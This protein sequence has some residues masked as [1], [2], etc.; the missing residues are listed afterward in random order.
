MEPAA[1]CVAD[2]RSKRRWI[3]RGEHHGEHVALASYPRCGNTLLRSLLEALFG[4]YT[5]CD[6]NP[7]RS[8]SKELQDYGLAGEGQLGQKVWLVKTH[9]P[10]REGWKMFE[11]QRA[12][13]LVR[14]PYDAIDSY[15]NQTMTNTHTTSVHESQYERFAAL[16]DGLMKHEAIIWSRFLEYWQSAGIPVLVLRYEDVIRYPE[17]SLLDAVGFLRRLD[18]VGLC[19]GCWAERCKEAVTEVL[20]S[21]GEGSTYKPR[22]GTVGGSLRH[23]SPQQRVA[24]QE[25]A[26]EQMKLFGYSYD[27]ATGAL[28]LVEDRMSLVLGHNLT[29][30]VHVNACVANPEMSSELLRVEDDPYGRKLCRFRKALPQPVLS[31]EGTALNV[32]EVERSAQ[33]PVDPFIRELQEQV[34][35]GNL[36]QTMPVGH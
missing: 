36:L 6:T 10:E 8:L 9:Y 16:W 20:G 35:E 2:G 27:E 33:F 13:L 17:Q 34:G 3:E 7:H 31:L 4:C 22:K 18:E 25:L 14:N 21:K 1:H 11:V 19:K 30:V 15:F 26:A 5:G 32:E 28:E 29:G 23:Y 12:I 24:V